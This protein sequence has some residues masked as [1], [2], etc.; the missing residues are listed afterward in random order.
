MNYTALKSTELNRLHHLKQKVRLI[1][2]DI[3]FLKNC[4]RHK[5]FPNFIKV[6]T[7]V[8]NNVTEKVIHNVKVNWLN[9]EIKSLFSKQASIELEAYEFHLLIVKNVDAFELQ[10][11]NEK[12]N[13]M[14]ES[15]EN[16]HIFKRTKLEKKFQTLRKAA[17]QSEV[18]NSSINTPDTDNE[19][20]QNLSSCTFNKSEMDILKKGLNYSIRP[21]KH[22]Q[23]E[24]LF[25]DIE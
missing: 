12:Y 8:K 5:I 13:S 16:K 25:A 4:K 2:D 3:Y 22:I 20:V 10:V 17:Q 1:S 15:I 23:N 18:N 11:F 14:L 7:A 6:N 9:L 19:L 21:N 24:N